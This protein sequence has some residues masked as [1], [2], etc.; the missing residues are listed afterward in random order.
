MSI[1]LGINFKSHVHF[2]Y[3]STTKLND[4]TKYLYHFIVPKPQKPY[5]TLK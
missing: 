2:T 5:Q 3:I 1:S 4:N